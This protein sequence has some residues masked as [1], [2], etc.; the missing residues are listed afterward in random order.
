MT[1]AEKKSCSV[2]RSSKT[3]TS[4]KQ[5]HQALLG[6]TLGRTEV[7][8]SNISQPARSPPCKSHTFAPPSPDGPAAVR[9]HPSQPQPGV[10]I[11]PSTTEEEEQ[12]PY[13]TSWPMSSVGTGRRGRRQRWKQRHG[14]K[15][16]KGLSPH[17]APPLP[18]RCSPTAAPFLL[19]PEAFHLGKKG[20]PTLSMFAAC[21]HTPALEI[22]MCV[23]SL[24]PVNARSQHQGVPPSQNDNFRVSRAILIYMHKIQTLISKD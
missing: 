17:G 14:Q 18:G 23:L 24:K 2:A 11:P 7:L 1:Y 3:T 4:I 8:W 22:L 5:G 13:L 15:H 19:P 20:Q 12:G 21:H 16:I 10:S 6:F 9:F